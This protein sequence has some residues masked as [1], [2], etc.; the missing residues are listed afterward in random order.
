LHINGEDSLQIGHFRTF[1]TSLTLPLTL[2]LGSGYTAYLSF[3][4]SLI[5][6]YLHIKFRWNRKT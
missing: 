5:D 4:V 2:F 6:I 3:H 1:Q